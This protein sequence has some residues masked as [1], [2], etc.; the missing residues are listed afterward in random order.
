[1]NLAARLEG[2]NKVF[3]SAILVSESTARACGDAITMRELDLIRV[4]GREAPISVYEPICLTARLDPGVAENLASFARAL[5]LYRE[6][7]FEAAAQ[8]LE[9]LAANDS[10]AAKFAARAREMMTSPPPA[11][12]RGINELSQK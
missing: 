10:V 8:I 2:A 7:G 5:A 12:W 9:G 4:I 11:D 1:V 6:R 3:A